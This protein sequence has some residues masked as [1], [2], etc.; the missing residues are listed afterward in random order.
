[1]NAPPPTPPPSDSLP[2]GEQ[3][4]HAFVDGQLSAAEQDAVRARLQRDPAAAA[5]VAAWQAQR[6]ALRQWAAD[7]ELPPAP[8]ADVLRRAARTQVRRDWGRR[9][10]AAALLLGLG[11]GGG[12]QWGRH[13][14]A[15]SDLDRLVQRSPRGEPAA[16]PAFAREAVV[17]HA[18]FAAEKRHPVEVGAAEQAHLVQWLSRRLGRPLKLPVLTAQGYAL[19]GGRLLPGDPAEPASPRAQFMYENADGDRL[20]LF[21]AV[22]APG[23]AGAGPTEFRLLHEGRRTSLYWRDGDFGYALSSEAADELPLLAQQVHQQLAG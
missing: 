6:Q 23:G 13:D 16:A 11:L 10:L 9:G 3:Q 18:V 15:P 5:R 20:T 4:L 14:A 2:P 19:L 22:F 7:Q 21:V 12:Y 8:M 1:M 17:A